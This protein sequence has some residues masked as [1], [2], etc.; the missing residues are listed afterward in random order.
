LHEHEVCNAM[1]TS[2]QAL[3]MLR[4]PSLYEQGLVW[5]L[6]SQ[7]ANMQA[8]YADALPLSNFEE[9][10]KYKQEGCSIKL[11]G[12]EKLSADIFAKGQHFASLY[13]HNGSVTSFMF[14]SPAGS[15]S[16][17]MH[18]DPYDVIIHVCEGVKHMMV[19]NESMEIAAGSFIHIPAHVPH[20]ALN[21][22]DSI[23]LSFGLE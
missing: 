1:I 22:H 17:P 15:S 21:T 23:I 20:V 14:I 11:E 5:A 18:T 19:N 4:N 3:Q 6:G 7:H 10:A 16:F 13:K 9:M 2:A 12:M 8:V